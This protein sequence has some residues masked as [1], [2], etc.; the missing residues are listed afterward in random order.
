M[1]V[2]IRLVLVDVKLVHVIDKC[3]EELEHVWVI[4]IA[5][6]IRIMKGRLSFGQYLIVLGGTDVQRIDSRE[7]SF[8]LDLVL[9]ERRRS[10][11]GCVRKIRCQGWKALG[12]VSARL[13]ARANE[14]VHC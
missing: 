5:E 7:D 8:P 1:D 9:D 10:K 6:V 11:V 12:F 13:R 14:S 4:L 3:I 2:G